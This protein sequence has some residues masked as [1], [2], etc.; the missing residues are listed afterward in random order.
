MTEATQTA[1]TEEGEQL[2]LKLMQRERLTIT[3]QVFGLEPYV[4][5]RPSITEDDGEMIVSVEAGGGADLSN[6]GEFLQIIA[7]GLQDPTVKDRIA[8]AILAAAEADQADEE[9]DDWDAPDQ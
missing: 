9:D 4:I 1:Y 6:V 7:E 8:A 2:S 5:I 3:T